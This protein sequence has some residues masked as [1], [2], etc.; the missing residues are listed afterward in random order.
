MSPRSSVS[1]AS[2]SLERP[3]DRPGFDVDVGPVQAGGP[4][5]AVRVVRP[6]RPGRTRQA[7]RE[8]AQFLVEIPQFQVH[9]PRLGLSAQL[10]EGGVHVLDGRP[11]AL[12]AVESARLNRTQGSSA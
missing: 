2:Y 8:I 1:K 4:C 11:R 9:L 7:S 12:G 3:I 6:G 10:V 5:E